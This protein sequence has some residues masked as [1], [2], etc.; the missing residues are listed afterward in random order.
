MLV[1]QELKPI[2]QQ[3]QQYR[4]LIKLYRQSETL[5]VWIFSYTA[6]PLL[7][8]DLWLIQPRPSAKDIKDFP[9]YCCLGEGF[10]GVLTKRGDLNRPRSAMG[11]QGQ[12]EKHWGCFLLS[13]PQKPW[14]I[15]RQGT[16]A[17]AARRGLLRGWLWQGPRHLRQNA[18]EHGEAEQNQPGRVEAVPP[19]PA[20]PQGPPGAA[21]RGRGGAPR[22][23]A[24]A[25]SPGSPEPRPLPAAPHLV[26]LH[27]RGAAT[28]RHRPLAGEQERAAAAPGLA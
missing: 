2:S 17:A 9:Y 25:G 28:R 6:Y 10:L 18:R 5:Q 13:L 15:Q 21:Q 24:P 27:G 1:P 22:Q 12:Q 8:K 16:P 20:P 4:L 3:S 19:P 7:Q 11:V 14:L 23:A 26:T